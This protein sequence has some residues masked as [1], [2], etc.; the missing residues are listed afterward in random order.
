MTMR[1]IL[2]GILSAAAL[3]G[4]TFF[5]DMVMK[6]TFLIGNYL[7]LSVFGLLMIFVLGVNPLLARL[8]RRAMLSGRELA[9]IVAI[10]IFGCYVPGRGLMHYFTTFMIL[11]YHHERTNPGWPGEPPQIAPDQVRDWPALAAALARGARAPASDPLRRAFERLPA[12]ARDAVAAG[13]VGPEAV[14]TRAAV[15]TALNGALDDSAL[16]RGAPLPDHAPQYLRILA[17]RE[18]AGLSPLDHQRLN[19]GLLDAALRGSL[20]PRRPGVIENA[21]PRMLVDVSRDATRVLDGFVTG[22]AQ[23]KQTLPYRDVPWHAWWRPLLFWVPLIVTMCVAVTG[24]ALVIHRQ[25]ASHEHLPYPTVEFVRSVLPEPGAV[26]SSIF[27]RRLF[28]AGFAVVFFIHMDNYAAMWWPSVV[29][30]V[31][32]RLDFTPLADIVPIFKR[33]GTWALFDPTLYFTAIGF[34][35]FLSSDVALSLGLA[36]YVFSL[37]IGIVLGFGVPVGGGMLQPS[38]ESFLYAGSYTGMFLALAYAGRRYY[39]TVFARSLGLPAGDTAEAHAVWG[40]R[41]FLLAAALFVFQLIVVGV[42]WQFA[43]LYTLGT[44]MIYV[45]ISRLLVEAGAFFIHAWFYPC[46]VL[47]GFM[48]AMAAGQGQLLILGMLSSLL[49]IDP[50]EALMPFVVSGI[51]L[52]DQAGQRLGRLAA[53]GLLAMLVG[54]LVAIPV[55]LRWQ[56]QDGGIQTGDGWTVGGVSKFAFSLSSEIYSSLDAQGG[57]QASESLSG[58]GRF[59]RIVPQTPCVVA[60]AITFALTLLFTF[61]RRRFAGWPLHPLL[62][63]VLGTWQGRSLGFSF[64]LGWLIKTVVT[65]LGGAA[66]Y[67]RLKPLMIGLVAGEVVAGIVPVIIG[68][69][70]YHVTGFPPKYFRILPA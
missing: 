17:A 52:A 69:I 66:A 37:A 63:L 47:W 39:R 68:A 6:G 27:R 33:V 24:L 57:V 34:A 13:T 51:R 3:G 67:Q 15:L 56:Y 58:P 64:L 54:F 26:V 25:W 50:R 8:S 31:N 16:H 14:E 21:P 12:D 42:E 38:V 2:I 41:V 40:A 23:G 60:F 30:P 28:W 19:R 62:F 35:Y 65:K 22:L 49:L 44:V 70:Y 61:L 11:P 7:P 20:K 29:I 53:W 46:A 4:V 36:P 59:L 45:V 43:V 32:I 9:V 1:S 18:G 5:N 55:A 48:G 10:T